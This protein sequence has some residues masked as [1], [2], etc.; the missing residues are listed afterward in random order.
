MVVRKTRRPAIEKGAHTFGELGPACRGYDGLALG[1][2]LIG[3]RCRPSGLHQPLHGS[4]RAGRPGTK[5][6]SQPDRGLVKPGSGMDRIDKTDLE[7][8]VGIEGSREQQQ[9][10]RPPLADQP[11]S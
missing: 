5:P 7:R 10:Q 4:L 11:S 1:F 9:L 3:Q 2:Q 8:S 6:T